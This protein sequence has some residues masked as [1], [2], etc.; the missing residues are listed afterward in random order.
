MTPYP[1][2]AADEGGSLAALRQAEALAWAFVEDRRAMERERLF[3]ALATIVRTHAPGAESGAHPVGPQGPTAGP[4]AR[5]V[6]ARSLLVLA[7]L[8]GALGLWFAGWLP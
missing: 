2:R 5:P 8:V 1:L 6:S 4:H 7:A 3:F